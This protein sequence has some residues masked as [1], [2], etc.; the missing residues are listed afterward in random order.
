MSERSTYAP[1][2]PNW[3]DLGTPDPDAAEAF[4]GPIFGWSF[5]PGENPEETGGYR[6]AMLRDQ[7]VAGVMKLMQEG[8]PPA[9]SNYISVEDADA[10]MEAVKDNGGSVAIEPMDILDI[11]RMGFFVDPTGAFCGVWQPKSFHG[12][13]L[14]NEPGSLAWNELE[15]RD[16][17]AAKVF[18]GAVFGWGSV[19]HEMERETGGGTYTEWQLDGNS[20]GGMMDVTGRVPD[21]VPA[22]W[23]A[24]F[25]V[26]DAD[27]AVEQVKATGG[28]VPFGPVDI[29]AG[30]FAMCADPWGAAFAV[31]KMPEEAA[32]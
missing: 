31:I 20:I 22:H 30:R 15:T 16:P 3:V 32:T 14:V 28:Q 19:D 27:A 7:P 21:R 24:Y 29:P 18:Y 9:W 8:Q 6:S 11:G 2:T 1:G 10:A 23:M 13:G 4:Y 17:S 5:D 26:A 12:A 25:A